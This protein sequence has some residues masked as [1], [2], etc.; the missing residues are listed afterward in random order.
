MNC[1]K[2]EIL[3]SC[4][5]DGEL[6]PNEE[7]VLMKHIDECSFCRKKLES[8]KV[9]SDQVKGLTRL[10]GDLGER[11]RLLA[12]LHDA[13]AREPAFKPARSWVSSNRFA[14]AGATIVIIVL[15][16]LFAIPKTPTPDLTPVPE[17][18]N[19]IALLEE[20]LI[21]GLAEVLENERVFASSYEAF[22][23]P[24][25]GVFIFEPAPPIEGYFDTNIDMP[26]HDGS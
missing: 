25:L 1:R 10:E 24:A 2:Y 8:M 13:I 15:I 22:S 16:A 7:A 12:S 19:E 3:I 26:V 9:L 21:N 14:W 18:D 17:P 23:E 11:N 4:Y 20:N 5:V 6:S